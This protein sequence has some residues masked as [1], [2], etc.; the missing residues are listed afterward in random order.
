MPPDHGVLA[1]GGADGRVQKEWNIEHFA[2]LKNENASYFLVWKYGQVLL[3][4]S[5]RDV[6]NQ[7][8]TYDIP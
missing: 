6:I 7:L 4:L 3:E 5:N 2:R 1:V 8:T